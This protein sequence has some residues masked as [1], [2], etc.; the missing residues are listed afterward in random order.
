[1]A[2]EI[3]SLKASIDGR[4]TERTSNGLD[5]V[6]RYGWAIKDAPGE[7]R[8][9]HKDALQIDSA[10]Q[11]DVLHGKVKLIASSWSWIGLGALV[12]GERDGQLWVIDGQHRALA[13]RKRSDISLLPCVVFKTDDVRTEARAFLDTNTGRKPV[14]TI[15]KQKAL[16]AAGDEIAVFIQQKFRENNLVATSYANAANQ[17]KAMAW[18][19]T[20]AAENK[21]TF[22]LVL[23]FTASLCLVDQMP[24][25]AR[26]LEG[27]W[28]LNARCGAGLADARLVKRLRDAGARTLLDAANRA[29]AFYARGG[30]RVWATGMLNEI[31][32]GLR[33]K[34]AMDSD[35]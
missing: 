24:V 27:I 14:T 15:S 9:V 12:V 26:L 20:R 1:M 28:Y 23:G 22:S 6:A 11:R 2:F 34:F 21:E 19:N 30:G 32:K 10:Y 5:K 35:E 17:I 31:N 18:C 25:H 16:V 29:A 7:L 13:A 3:Q 33:H 8:M 4:M